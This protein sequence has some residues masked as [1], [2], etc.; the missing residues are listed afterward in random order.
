MSV[1][2]FWAVK[3]CGLVGIKQRFGGIYCFYL[4]GGIYY[5]D[6]PPSK[7]LYIFLEFAMYQP[8]VCDVEVTVIC[9]IM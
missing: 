7:L 4:Q 5:L 9:K 8:V 1:M 3:P 2:V 6:E